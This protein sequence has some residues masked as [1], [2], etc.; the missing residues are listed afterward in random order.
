LSETV[1]YPLDKATAGTAYWKTMMSYAAAYPVNPTAEDKTQFA[2]FFKNLL[3]S[4]PCESC[5][6]HSKEYI[7][8]HPPDTHSRKQLFDWMCQFENHV[9]AEQGKE[10]LTCKLAEAEC[11][12][13]N[14]TDLKSTFKDLKEV[15]IRVF[16]E[17]CTREKIPMPTIVFA[18]CPS[19]PFTSCT[20][21]EKDLLSGKIHQS[22]STVFLNPDAYSPRTIY[23]EFIHY[24]MFHKGRDDVATDEWEVERIAQEAMKKEFPYDSIS[25]REEAPL[26]VKDTSPYLQPVKRN[27]L[28]ELNT[29]IEQEFPLFAKYKQMQIQQKVEEQQASEQGGVLSVFDSIYQP[30]EEHF[31]LS[32]RAINEMHTS[33]ILAASATTLMQSNLSPFGS[34]VASLLTGIGLLGAG[35]LAKKNLSIGDR[36]FLS[37]MGSYLLWNN[38]AYTNPKVSNDVMT[39][40][41]AAGEAAKSFD[42]EAIKNIMIES[43]EKRALTAEAQAQAI[44]QQ[45][46]AA[47]QGQRGVG[48][49]AGGIQ[50]GGV[51]PTGARPDILKRMEQRAAGLPEGPDV[52]R[53]KEFPTRRVGRGF[54]GEFSP[55]Y[56]EGGYASEPPI[57]ETA[58]VTNTINF[59]GE[60]ED[61][62][63]DLV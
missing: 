17:L 1:T 4:F 21:M 63:S 27:Y 9:R 15:S 3:R 26:I 40:A 43:P 31:G 24:A 50:R 30:L 22:K 11:K 7:L 25:K 61:E 56:S 12:S 20:H 44:H 49:R 33:N 13:C 37:E 19:A 59:W 60:S 46:V 38:L 39:D 62:M 58:P 47:R 2:I 53:F 36:R 57:A 45:K 34:A 42:F 52:T 18:P 29:N 6:K 41:K 48:G 54:G 10:P 51:R 5:R 28:D 55:N 35:V 32:K 23:H 14:L 16:Q 8:Q